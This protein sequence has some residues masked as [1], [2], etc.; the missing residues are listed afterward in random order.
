M[1]FGQNTR[2]ERIHIDIVEGEK[3]TEKD[4]VASRPFRV[5]WTYVG[6]CRI[7]YD[8]NN[9]LKYTYLMFGK[10]VDEDLEPVTDV[11]EEIGA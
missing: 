1:R 2:Y 6:R 11:S 8:D 7:I 9:W 5:C 4:G 10:K 3:G